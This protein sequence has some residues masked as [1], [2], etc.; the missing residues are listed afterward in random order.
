MEQEQHT[1]SPLD[2]K[3]PDELRQLLAN[4]DQSAFEHALD[5]LLRGR[6]QALFKALGHLAR[7]LNESVKRLAAEVAGPHAAT[8]ASDVRTRLTEVL[9]MSASATHRNLAMVEELRPRASQLAA[10][11]QALEQAS[12]PARHA[13]AD[14]LAAQAQRFARDAE[15]RFADMLEAQSWQDLAGQ[16]V[17]TVIGFVDRVE[18]ALL[19]LVR[20]TGSLAGGGSDAVRADVE[21]AATQDEVD[22][23]LSEFGF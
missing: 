8:G 1:P 22:R 18:V 20:L 7:D 11:A 14:E 5:A 4:D 16:R 15:T 19:E 12:E 6:E 9:Q 17:Q 3:L 13:R 21:R 23:L 10:C 2:P